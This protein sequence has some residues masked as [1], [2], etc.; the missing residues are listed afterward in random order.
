MNGGDEYLDPH[1]DGTFYVSMRFYGDK[2]QIS[3]C[4]FCGA[5]LPQN[6]NNKTY[7]GRL[8]DGT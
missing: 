3:F 8:I 6:T 4:P 2:K 5:H 1:D 7:D